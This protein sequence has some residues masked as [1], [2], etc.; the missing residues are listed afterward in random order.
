MGRV[1]ITDNSKRFIAI[2]ATVMDNA[3]STMGEDVAN[4]AKSRVPF[5]GGDLFKSIKHVKVKVLKHRVEVTEDYAGYQEA[6]QRADGSHI[7]RNYSTPGTG[8]GFLLGAGERVTS[9][10]LNYFKQ[11]VRLI[12]L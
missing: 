7:V 9:Q 3:L 1:I 2:N 12:R 8:K 10:A 6:G 5:K 11:A 4:I